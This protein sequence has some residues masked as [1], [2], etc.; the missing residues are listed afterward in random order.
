MKAYLDSSVILRRFLGET[1]GLEMLDKLTWG[2]SS[3]VTRLECVRTLDRLHVRSRIDSKEF[4]DLRRRCLELMTRLEIA[5]LTDAL[6]SLAESSFSVPLGSLDSIHL[7]SAILWQKKNREPILFLT[8]DQ[9]LALAAAS[10]GFN[11]KGV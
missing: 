4:A 5:Q 1:G 3:Q 8:H 10:Q 7:A 6:I 11:I 2:V 9:E